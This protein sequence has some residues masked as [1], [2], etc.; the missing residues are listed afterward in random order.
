DH[1][2]EV[3]ELVAAGEVLERR[4]RVGQDL[5]VIGKH[6]DDAAPLVEIEETRYAAHAFAN[7][8]AGAG[9]FFDCFEKSLRD[10]VS[11]CVNAHG[12]Y[13][14]LNLRPRRPRLLR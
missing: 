13:S 4:H 12:E 11:I 14:G 2:G 1:A 3:A 10:E 6:A 7:I 9:N 5:R 8:R